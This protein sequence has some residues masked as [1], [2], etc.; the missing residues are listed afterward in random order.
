V[1]PRYSRPEITAIWADEYKFQR[2]LDV[3][4]AFPDE[5]AALVLKAFGASSLFER[6][7]SGPLAG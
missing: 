4:I 1:I 7:P 2:W 6:R 5:V 3:E